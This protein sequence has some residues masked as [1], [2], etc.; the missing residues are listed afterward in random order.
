MLAYFL[1]RVAL[2]ILTLFLT[3][4]LIFF[5]TQLL[6]GDV[7]RL[8][9]GREASPERVEA[10]RQSFGL[11]DPAPIQYVRWLGGFLSGDWGI[12]F[13]AGNAPVRP[14]VLARLSN[15]LFLALAALSLSV[16]V[17]I[18]LGMLAAL[19]ENTWL[20]NLISIGTLAITGLPEFIVGIVL[21]NSLALGLGWFPATSLVMDGMSLGEWLRILALPALTASF[22]LIGYIARLTRAGVAEELKK[23]YVRT[24]LLKGL[25]VWQVLTRHVLRNA[26]LPVIT[27][28][29]ISTGW[30]MGGMVVIE[31]IYSYPGLGSELVRAVLQKNLPVLQAITIITV[32]AFAG[33]NFVADLLYAALNPRIRLS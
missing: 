15:S 9:L 21:V 12:S 31:N 16:P 30:L 22:V 4:A 5:L 2:L 24:A 32:F 7:A 23:S 8:I 11:N 14:F 17:G 10:F 25:S 19:R 27:V 33:A 3:S 13:S 29:A 18:G 26:L 20:D 1:R 6:P 28:V